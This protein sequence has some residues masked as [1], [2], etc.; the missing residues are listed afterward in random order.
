MDV[1]IGPWGSSASAESSTGCKI[2]RE[3]V[4]CNHFQRLFKD[5]PEL[6]RLVICGEEVVGCILP[7]APF[8]LV[9]LFLDFQGFQVVKLRL[10]RLKFGM[11]FI[12]AGF[13]LICVSILQ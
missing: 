10:V 1:W 13:L 5:F 6:D 12:F 2:V 7:P 11:E 9:D 3:V 8:D 4:F